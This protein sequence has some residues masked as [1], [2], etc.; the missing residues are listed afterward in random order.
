MFDWSYFD[1]SN[2]RP[3]DQLPSKVGMFGLDLVWLISSKNWVEQNII[4]TKSK[5]ELSSINVNFDKLQIW[6]YYYL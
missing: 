1:N 6:L 2:Q 3:F 4:R 5:N